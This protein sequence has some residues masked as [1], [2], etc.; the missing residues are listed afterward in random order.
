MH[1]ESQNFACGSPAHAISRR[2]MLGTLGGLAGFGS[3][4]HPAIARQVCNQHKRVCLIWL[5][6]GISQ[7]ESWHPLPDSKF[8]GPFRSIH[9][10]LPGVRFSELMPQTAK[11]AHKISVIR[12]MATKDPD[13]STG[14]PRIQR[15]DPLDR[16]VD[17]PTL[18][19]AIARLLG[20]VNPELPPYI[21]IKPGNG[22]F[23]HREAGFLGAQ[24]GALAL[25]DGR[26]PIHIHRPETVSAEVDMARNLLRQKANQR[27]TA[28]RNS[29]DIDAYETSY[30][31]ARQLMARK[32]IFDDNLLDP[33]DRAR[34]GSHPLG[35]HMLQA[36]QLLEAGVRFV[37]VNSYHWDT[38]GDNFN[39][40]Q[41]LVPQIDQPFAALVNDLDDRGMLEDTLVIVMSEFGRTPIINSRLGRDH[42]PDCWSIALAGGGTRPGAIVGETTADGAFVDSEGYDIGHLFHT[43]FT[44]LGINPRETHYHNKS[45][46]LAIARDDCQPIREVM[47]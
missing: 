13:H 38:H 8:A 20:P 23:I 2:R 31:M 7:Y 36:R 37:K 24:Y 35:R 45:Q 32:D 46:Q 17:Y 21:W 25:G 6:G 3:L 42:W 26:P 30:K 4:L 22:G 5:D 28:Y 34:Y 10:S 18:G 16:G 40:S 29:S 19:S 33:K 9:T 43:I 12:T 15:G 27:F 41:R 14:V 11:I 39:M 47:L 44:L 1:P